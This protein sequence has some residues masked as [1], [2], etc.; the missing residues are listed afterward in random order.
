MQFPFSKDDLKDVLA[1][2]TGF[3]KF[4][5]SLPE[6]ERNQL[7][8][9]ISNDSILVNALKFIPEPY[10][11]Q[12]NTILADIFSAPQEA[13]RLYEECRFFEARDLLHKTVNLYSNQNATS[14]KALDSA[15]E[16]GT[17]RVLAL[18]HNLLGDVEWTLGNPA[19]AFRHHQL[20]LSLAEET[21]DLDTIVTSLQSLGT[22]YRE[23]GDFEQGLAHY[24]KALELISG[25]RDRWRLQN[26]ILTS[27]GILYSD[28]GQFDKAV[29]YSLQA[30]DLCTHS[31]DTRVLPSCLNNLA[32]L[33]LEQNDFDLAIG[34]LEKGLEVMQSEND[35]RQN[36]LILNNLAMCYLRRKPPGRDVAKARSFLDEALTI[37]KKNGALSLQALSIGNIGFVH[38]EAGDFSEARQAFLNS[39]KIFRK[40]GAH[41]SEAMALTNLGQLLR[42][43]LNDLEGASQACRKAID[44]IEEI[45]GGF[46]KEIHRISY[47]GKEIEPYALMVGCLLD[48]GRPDQALEYVER[49][50][51]R[52]LLDFLTRKLMEK[53]PSKP[54]STEFQRAV[55]ILGEIDEIRKSLEEICRKD[56]INDGMGGNRA[57]RHN[58]ENLTHSLLKD[59]ATKESI[60]EEVFSELTSLD[61]ERASMIRVRPPSV[62]E[63]HE[64]FDKETLFLELYQTE[65][66]L[67]VL[68]VSRDGP[69]D[70][71]TVDL[72]FDEAMDTVLGLSAGIRDNSSLNVKSHEYI[73]K[74]RQPLARLFDLIVT[75]LQPFIRQYKQLIIAPH[76]FWHYFPFQALYDRDKKTYLCDQYEIG[77]SPSA[78]VLQLCKL[79]NRTDRDHAL[80]ISRSNGVLPHVDEEADLLAAAFYPNG[81]VFK[82]RDAH[83]GHIQDRESAYHVIHLACHGEFHQVQPFLSGID[84]PL[85]KTGRTWTY[86]IDFFQLRLDSSLVTLSA[87]ESGLSKFT[88]GDELIGMSRGLFY[89]GAASVMLSLWQVADES[90]C[91]LMENFYWHFVKNRQTKARALQLA[92]QAVKA[93]EKYAHPYFWAP[94]VVL[95]DW[96]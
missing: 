8:E 92:M 57:S 60:F 76:L 42:D 77:Y 7:R 45:R 84:M 10:R 54:N 24:H 27:L 1:S 36:A 25:H 55:A 28:I 89:A 33:Y 26:K 46:A 90:T 2:D 79:K 12:I 62:G 37:S 63:I 49:S 88:S 70:A 11:E 61:P 58:Y 73:K 34:T 5:D 44:I 50:K 81:H 66:K 67:W 64:L 75:P 68:I 23:T 22:Y 78:S 85:A 19:R 4:L 32:C 69:I 15:I 87:C 18:C 74:I 9:L 72:S 82:G 71:V 47:A 20:A 94:F 3:E 52:A 56:E 83:L 51:S 30:V 39:V 80:I 48:L 16:F 35:F 93:R 21:G 53:E 17:K 6:Q 40:I 31:E 13:K 38:K 59:L 95:G 91:Y 29:E 43:S 41:S 86:L 14:I 65:E 96:R